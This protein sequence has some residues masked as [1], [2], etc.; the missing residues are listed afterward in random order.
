[1]HTIDR[2][3]VIV[4]IVVLDIIEIVCVSTLVAEDGA[5]TE[6]YKCAEAI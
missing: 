1:M 3:H 5:A 6:A 4:I 2:M